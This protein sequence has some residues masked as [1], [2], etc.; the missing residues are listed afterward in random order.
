MRA[1]RLRSSAHHVADIEIRPLLN[2][3]FG[4]IA[5]VAKSYY[6]KNKK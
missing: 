5:F 1:R 4:A 3:H 6:S 2:S